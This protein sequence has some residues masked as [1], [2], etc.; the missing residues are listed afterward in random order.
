MASPS[1]EPILHIA[2][3]PCT[4]LLLGWWPGSVR[5]RPSDHGP[6]GI[7]VSDVMSIVSCVSEPAD[8]YT[9]SRE[10]LR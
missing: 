3:G 5:S 6:L 7:R 2:S 4:V 1:P 10:Q 9:Y 8:L